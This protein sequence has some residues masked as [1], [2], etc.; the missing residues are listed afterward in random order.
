VAAA[1]V[2]ALEARPGPGERELQE[3][4]ALPQVQAA[5]ERAEPAPAPEAAARQAPVREVAQPAATAPAALE[6][7][8]LEREAWEGEEARAPAE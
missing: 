7:E 6:R 5:R 8:V 1:V 4:E 3:V 2:P